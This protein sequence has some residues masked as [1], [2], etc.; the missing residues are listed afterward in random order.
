MRNTIIGAVL[1]AILVAALFA[2]A[3]WGRHPGADSGAD[4]AKAAASLTA[5]FVGEK[6]IGD[7][8]I[9]CG[10]PKA[11]PRP[12][13]N[14]GDGGNSE[15]TPPQGGPPEGF[16]FPR[17]HTIVARKS[18]TGEILISFRQFGFKRVL[19]LFVRLAPGAVP[20]GESVTARFDKTDRAI[21]LRCAPRLC[22]GVIQFRKAEQPVVLHAA[23]MT[24]G[25]KAATGP[26]GID[27]PTR[28]LPEAI[29][30]MQRINK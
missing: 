6:R 26:V 18:P 30:A 17:C 29:E 21:P 4:P 10:E 28:G 8:H 20:S 23:T 1:A 19:T 25:F 13:G 9:V 16:M 24:I 15:G 14:S 12:P 3:L 5:D 2:A 7:W 22:L 27:V 11:F